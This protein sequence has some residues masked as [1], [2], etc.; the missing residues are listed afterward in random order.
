M[1]IDTNI[2]KT[3][4]REIIPGYHAKIIHSENMTFVYWTI[5]KNKELPEHSHVNEQ[6]THMLSGQFELMIEKENKILKSGDVVIIPPH[7]KHS[8][9]S[10]TSCKILDVFYP[11]REDYK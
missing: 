7:I 8:G 1:V 4:E 9:R 11:I 5:E 2:E 3:K 6:V 10:R